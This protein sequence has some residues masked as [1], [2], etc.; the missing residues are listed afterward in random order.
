[1]PGPSSPSPP[2]ALVTGGAGF[3]G[4]HLVDGLLARGWSVTA[5]DDL[6]T[7]SP[8]NV[9]HHLGR[10]D[11]RLVQD[12]VLSRPVVDSLVERAD[13]VYHLAASVGVRL[14]M[15]RPLQSLLNNIHGTE[16]VLD[17]A[18]RHGVE[19]L[20]ASSSEIYGKSAA[21][22]LGEDGD[23]LLGPPR[24]LRW[25]YSTGKAVDEILA[26][27]YCRD[28]GLRTVIARLF[29]TAGPRQAGGPGMVLPRL[30]GQALRGEPLT[31]Y[32]D[33]TQTR[34]FTH[35]GDVVEA[36]VRLMESPVAGEAFNVAG[37]VAVTIQD[38]AELILR[39]TGSRAGLRH[40]PLTEVYGADFEE[41]HCRVADTSRLERVTGY[42]CAT[43]L[44]TIVDQT[45][46]HLR[47]E[48]AVQA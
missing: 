35:V 47:A 9:R 43:D 40:V 1:M 33:G 18:L 30:A 22:P 38:L 24:K 3:I 26:H 10:S 46:A 36:M 5:L 37:P 12:S 2:A 39:R 27:L 31:V 28:F 14:V 25:S 19:V 16:V 15:E 4:S 17:A 32:G 45:I 20:V 34:T 29:N 13:V 23:R 8:R 42:R 21:T 48:L 41:P 11:F 6:S 7:G 44:D